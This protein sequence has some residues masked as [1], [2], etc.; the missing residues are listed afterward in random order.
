VGFQGAL[1]LGVVNSDIERSTM[2]LKSEFFPHLAVDPWDGE[3]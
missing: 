3:E 2:G 1:N